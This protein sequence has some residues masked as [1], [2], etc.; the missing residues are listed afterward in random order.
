M[1]RKI[2]DEIRRRNRQKIINF[3]EVE[4]TTLFSEPDFNIIKFEFFQ[5]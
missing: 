2:I 4:K 1:K 3:E 5:V